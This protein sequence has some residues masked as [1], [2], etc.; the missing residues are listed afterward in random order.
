VA[1]SFSLTGSLRLDPRWVDD[2]NTTL[3]TD[4]T[5][6]NLALSLT[7]GDGDGEAD[8]YWRDVRTVAGGETDSVAMAAGL[9]LSVFGGSG[10]VEL[11]PGKLRLLYVRNLSDTATL[12]L[13]LEDLEQLQLPPRG[14]L[15]LSRPADAS[16]A[17]GNAGDIYIVN[18]SASAADYEIL[19]IGVK[20][21]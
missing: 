17:G 10:T 8:A 18:E 5:R 6:F 13:V 11:D 14:V 12:G 2:L 7:N 1:A 15:L 16:F 19:L 21:T 3:V 4:A 9:P 20:A